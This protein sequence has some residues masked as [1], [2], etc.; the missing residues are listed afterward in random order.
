MENTDALYKKIKIEIK[1][2]IQTL[3]PDSKIPTRSS[4][5]KKFNV[6]RPT[7]DRAIS[8]LIGEGYLFSKVGSGTYVRQDSTSQIKK[9]VSENTWGL[10]LQSLTDFSFPDLI[11]G[12][13]DIC[14]EDGINLIL[15]NCDFNYEKQ[16]KYIDNLIAMGA[17]GIIAVPSIDEPLESQTRFSELINTGMKV[18]FC[19]GGNQ[20]LRIPKVITNDFSGA[21]I[22]VSHIIDMGWKKPA[23]VGKNYLQPTEQRYAGYLHSL[24]KYGIPY[25]PEHVCLECTKNSGD[26]LYDIVKRMLS[27]PNPPDSFFATNDDSATEV[28]RAVK[29]MGLII[30]RDIGVI[31]Y[32]NTPI[33][34]QLEPKL[35]SI[36]Q[37]FYDIGRYAAKTLN[38]MINTDSFPSHRTIILQPLL[39]S[40]DSL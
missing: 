35:S 14:S 8:E 9:G 26:T 16:A 30:G 5:A 28:Y 38:E 20:S 24:D 6:T 39:V 15:C 21:A 12:V 40:R 37:P 2:L 1:E 22:A 36:K 17:R 33:C 32:D 10:I 29:D 23:F 3:P 31:G 7:I 34:E 25:R 27:L 13:E 11:R 18:V 19:T 4:F